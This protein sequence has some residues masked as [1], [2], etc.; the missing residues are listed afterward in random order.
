MEKNAT[1]GLVLKIVHSTLWCECP[2]RNTLRSV[3]KI[4]MNDLNNR[5]PSKLPEDLCC[6]LGAN[7]H[8]LDM[9]A[10]LWRFLFNLF[11][12]GYNTRYHLNILT[13]I[14]GLIGKLSACLPLE[15]EIGM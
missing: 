7:L 6:L 10:P 4:Q 3:F 11:I 8:P 12:S 5:V 2:A 15:L 9:S 14:S 13:R 1:V